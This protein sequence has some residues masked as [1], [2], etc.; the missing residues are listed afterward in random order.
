MPHNTI[1][2]P[3]PLPLPTR[4]FPGFEVDFG[5]GAGAGF[6][7]ALGA[8]FCG[9]HADI[10]CTL[11]GWGRG[12]RGRSIGIFALYYH[13]MCIVRLVR[14]LCRKKRGGQRGVRG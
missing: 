13:Y 4:H 2:Q 5:F 11:G 6:D 3:L 9:G 12:V 7:T 1:L 10:G 14:F 8:G